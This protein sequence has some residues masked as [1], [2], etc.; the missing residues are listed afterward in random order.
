[1]TDHLTGLLAA[2]LASMVGRRRC[3]TSS[4][5]HPSP[6]TAPN[7][8]RIPLQIPDNTAVDCFITVGG[9]PL[10]VASKCQLAGS[11][12]T[13]PVRGYFSGALCASTPR[14]ES[15]LTM[16]CHLCSCFPR[17]F[18]SPTTASPCSA[19]RPPWGTLA[20]STASRTPSAIGM[21]WMRWL[22]PLP[23]TKLSS[24]SRARRV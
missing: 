16:I 12:T 3:L 11:A 9:G 2:R 23:R 17:R 13:D 18:T 7:D 22:L 1:M 8:A 10:D 4:Q 19:Q 24:P 15:H 5:T 20:S 14:L 6:L 21:L